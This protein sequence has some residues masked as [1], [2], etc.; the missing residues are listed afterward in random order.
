M[1]DNVEKKYLPQFV[2]LSVDPVRDNVQ[3]LN[4]YI[5]YFNDEF[6]AATG[7]LQDIVAMEGQF[8]VFHKYDKPNS[9][10][11]YTVTHSAEIFLIDPKV[12]IIAKFA[13]PISTQKVT[14]QYQDL[15]DYFLK[16]NKQT[17]KSNTT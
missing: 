10:G 15:V 9:D 1:N 6:I 16:Q 14:R 2:F 7:S 3:L 5:K 11:N 4:E 13:P 17:V 12:R 8:N